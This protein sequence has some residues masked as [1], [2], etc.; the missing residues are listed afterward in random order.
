MSNSFN[1]IS[2]D[3]LKDIKGICF[4][5]DDTITTNGKLIEKSYSSLWNLK[6]AGF[7]LVP[8]TGRPA[9]WCD[10]IVRYWPVDAIVGENGAFTFFMQDGVRKRIDTM[11][12]VNLD[13]IKENLSKL[14]KKITTKFPI[15]K[16]ASDQNYREYDLAIDICEDVTPWKENEVQALLS[17]CKEN[18]ASAKLSSIHVNTWFGDFDKA[19][20]FK[21]WLG[22][23]APGTKRDVLK[24]DEWIFIGDSP[25]DAPLFEV[26]SQSVAVANINRYLSNLKSK[27]TWICNSENGEGFYEF[28]E[29]LIAI[30]KIN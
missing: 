17:F 18:G 9:A 16:F 3:R 26:F 7:I 30:E 19:T 14:K 8:I 28:S 24:W 15:A 10:H 23:G 29:K 25:N 12:L 6:E 11:G 1:D 13:E 22:S 2:L 4:D 20:G 5:I 27:P 21:H